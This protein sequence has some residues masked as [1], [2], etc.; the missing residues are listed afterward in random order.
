MPYNPNNF[1]VGR[2]SYGGPHRQPCSTR[3]GIWSGTGGH[4][5]IS[6]ESQCRSRHI[7]TQYAKTDTKG[8][9]I[10]NANEMPNLP[11]EKH[12]ETVHLVSLHLHT[13]FHC[14]YSPE[15]TRSSKGLVIQV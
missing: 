13:I 10:K 7:R 9:V 3:H 6:H 2:Q 1:K 12:M 5:K 11:D 4:H 8:T 15:H 14:T